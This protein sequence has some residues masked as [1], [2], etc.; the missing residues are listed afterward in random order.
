MKLALVGVAPVVWL[1]GDQS[2]GD[3]GVQVLELGAGEEQVHLVLDGDSLGLALGF[4]LGEVFVFEGEDLPDHF[5]TPH[6]RVPD[7]VV[8]TDQ[9]PDFIDGEPRGVGDALVDACRWPVCVVR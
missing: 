9:V 4:F 8:Q 7:G 5:L 3:F 6:L 1:D 2:L